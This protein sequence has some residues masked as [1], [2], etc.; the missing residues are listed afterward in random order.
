MKLKFRIL[1]FPCPGEGYIWNPNNPV[2]N[3]PK[4]NVYPLDM[5]MFTGKPGAPK[6]NIHIIKYEYKKL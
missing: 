1:R 6:D 3:N 5:L 4:Q 2:I